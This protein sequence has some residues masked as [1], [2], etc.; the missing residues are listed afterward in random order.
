MRETKV[1][2]RVESIA[3]LIDNNIALNIPSY[4]R[5]FVWPV[6]DVEK[7]LFDIVLASECGQPQYFIGTTISAN[8]SD[9]AKNPDADHTYE[10]IDGQQRVT[11]LTILALAMKEALP[12]H[13]LINLTRLGNFPRLTF[14][15]RK[16]VQAYLA[17]EA[18]LDFDDANSSEDVDKT[19]ESPYVTQVR[20]GL[21]ASR[22]RLAQFRIDGYD[23]EKVAN[24]LYENVVWVNN[25]IP[26]GMNPNWLFVRVNTA[27]LQL[28]QSDILKAQ[29]LSKITAN[30][31]RY[32]AIWQACENLDNYFERNLRQVFP[33]A[34]WDSLHDDDLAQFD[35]NCFDLDERL[36][37]ESSGLCVAELADQNIDPESPSLNAKI[38]EK[39][40]DDGVHCRSIIPFS[41][42]LMHAYRVY[43]SESHQSDI[44]SR[45]NA[46]RFG[47]CFK[48]FS[49]E[50]NESQS[51]AFI[52][53]IW[54]V[55]YQFDRWV[56]KW[57]HQDGDE[58]S[59]LGIASVYS[60]ESKGRKRLGRRQEEI[61]DLVQLQA[62][63]NFS[64]ERS[65][66]YWLSPFLKQMMG[67]SRSSKDVALRCLEQIDNNLSL[68]TD[69]QKD[70][71]FCILKGAS[72]NCKD[73]DFVSQHLQEC[74]GTAF[75]HYWFLKLE[76]VLW[77]LRER[78]NF[79]DSNRWRD[80]RISSKNSIEH[81]DP[82]A[83]EYRQN[84][85]ELEVI[86]S[87][88]NLALLSPGENSSYS[89]QDPQ[90]KKVDFDNKTTYDSLKL[91]HIF[92]LMRN[93]GW[94]EE[95][96]RIHQ[97]IMID[98]LLKHYQ[99]C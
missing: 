55:R 71:S 23:I 61:S 11:S 93:D 62:V 72:L 7:L 66:Q 15:I 41:L 3:W 40:D 45:L 34:N 65:A 96:I 84:Q 9:S 36:E 95:K 80:F 24:Y 91:A 81:V 2:T 89:N 29:L 27:A 56:V 20:C 42:L 59:H 19:S 73:P 60:Y 49:R 25:I 1:H 5:P 85:K 54:R 37:H 82:Q 75:E 87:F 32:D 51:R 64:G 48:E 31:R 35:A 47:E 67:N 77:K 97:K 16:Q 38:D 53:C 10:L 18:G 98:I 76:Y 58:S 17:H 4:Q 78:L 6:E 44:N 22:Q 21:V 70:A 13:R 33:N 39:I 94:N 68:A 28:E 57:L 43:R 14:R 90:K 88:G 99:P 74:L 86:N 63:R 52:E 50:A 46:A 69:T 92:F 79:F 26:P 83:H 12:T 8:S 30:K